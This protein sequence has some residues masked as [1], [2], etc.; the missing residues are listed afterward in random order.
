MLTTPILNTIQTFDASNQNIF[1]FN[2][3][4]GNQ[5]VGN[6]LVI[7]RISDNA[8]VY[9]ATQETFN[10]R[11][12][13]PLLTL[14]NGTNYR[15]KVR[16]KDINNNWSSFSNSLLFWCYSEPVLN[17]TTIDYNNQNRVNNQTVLFET[18][19]SQAEDEIL[20]SYRYL[21]YNSNQE[22][23]K[24]FSE[25][26]ADGTTPLTQEITGLENDISYYLEVKTLSPN[27]NMGTTGLIN[28]K[29]FYIAPKLTVTVD[30]KNLLSQGAIQIDANIVQIILELYDDN[31]DA[32]NPLNV[33]YIDDEWIDITR[34]DY[35]KLVAEGGF[36]ILQSN[37][38]LQMWCKNLPD[39]KIFLTLF[40]PD[41]K[42]EMFKSNSRIRV[43]KSINNL[44]FK[45]YYVSDE[46][47]LIEGQ[48]IMIYMKQDSNLIDLKVELL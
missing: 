15:A 32:I 7:E 37:F 29:P 21:L 13:L 28:F 19:Y 35:D 36:N 46:F 14:I 10:L 12:T 24:S 25:I 42:I 8:V 17:I 3:V 43:Y 40:S 23:L 27:G 30:P 16:T 41:G 47:T 44:G 9:N 39:D 1:T 34:I 18:T 2:V 11:H 38:I 5:V 45:N 33:E 22:L 48:E 31:G 4:G 26:Y 6:N 20:Q